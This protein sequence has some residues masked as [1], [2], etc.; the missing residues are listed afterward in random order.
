MKK[1]INNGVV[2]YTFNIFSETNFL[3]H[4]FSTKIGGVSTG[5][6]ATMN[7][8][9][10]RDSQRDN[11][12]KNFN[13][14]CDAVGFKYND[15]VLIQQEHT[16]NVEVVTEENRG[17]ILLK[18]NDLGVIDGVVTNKSGVTLATLHADCVPIYFYDPIKKVIGLCHAG[19]KGTVD[20]IAEVTLTK[21]V[22]TYG[23][24]VEDILVGIGPS[25]GVCCFEVD[26]PVKDEFETKLPFCSKYIK[27]SK[28]NKYNIDM[29]QINKEILMENGV[30]DNNIEIGNICT[31]CNCDIF[32]SHRVS[33]FDRGC[34]VAMLSLE[35]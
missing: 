25:I 18:P 32:H 4:C 12:Y 8:A 35:S 31:K 21:M 29:W 2:Y 26:K 34:M 14:L 27:N 17:N 11:V 20:G 15:I 1:N 5:S 19:W 13:I 9:F 16:A 6:S 33:G 22:K 3:P 10:K 28:N 30:L 24:N 23:C 7:L